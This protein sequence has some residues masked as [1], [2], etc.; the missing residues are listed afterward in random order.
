MGMTGSGSFRHA[1]KVTHRGSSSVEQIGRTSNNTSNSVYPDS[2]NANDY[3]NNDQSSIQSSQDLRQR[4]PPK[5]DGT[6]LIDDEG[7]PIKKRGRTTCV[8]IQSMPLC[9]RIHIEDNENIVP[10]WRNKG[11]DPFK[12][13][14]LAEIEA[15]FEFPT[16]MKYWILQSLGVNLYENPCYY[17]KSIA[18]VKMDH[19]HLR[20]PDKKGISNFFL[21]LFASFQAVKCLQFRKFH[22]LYVVPEALE[23]GCT[24]VSL[25]PEQ[26]I[27]TTP[28]LSSVS[29]THPENPGLL[30][31]INLS[32]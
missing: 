28:C 27:E 21:M 3:N 25:D 22:N 32:T 23:H 5:E 6:W 13:K 14:M 20:R 26:A 8:D 19:D 2:S 29:P 10:Y 16:N 30:G 18:S 15:K 4:V 1:K 31:V 17:E 9:I 11:M 24:Q 12:K 7:A